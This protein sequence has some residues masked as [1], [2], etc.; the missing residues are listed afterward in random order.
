M[1]LLEL[2]RDGVVTALRSFA[3][4]GGFALQVGLREFGLEI[5]V[6]KESVW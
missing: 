4:S 6:G 5:L 2:V 3:R 1:L